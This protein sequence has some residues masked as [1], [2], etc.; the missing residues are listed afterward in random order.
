MAAA[1]FS[2]RW[3]HRNPVLVT[4]LIPSGVEWLGSI[5][6]IVNDGRLLTNP[7]RS[8]EP[9]ELGLENSFDWLDSESESLLMEDF[10]NDILSP[11]AIAEETDLYSSRNGLLTNFALWPGP[12]T[13]ADFRALMF[14]PW[15]SENFGLKSIII[16]PNAQLFVQ[17][18]LHRRHENRSVIRLDYLERLVKAHPEFSP[19]P[20]E[21][22]L[23]LEEHFEQYTAVYAILNHWLAWEAEQNEEFFLFPYQ[24]L[25]ASPFQAIS[26]L[27]EAV[28]SRMKRNVGDGLKA[29]RISYDGSNYQKIP[30]SP[31]DPEG[32]KTSIH[33]EQA[34][35]IDE[36]LA[37]MNCP[38]Q[39]VAQWEATGAEPELSSKPVSSSSRRGS[40]GRSRS[41]SSRSLESSSNHSFGPSV[42]LEEERPSGSRR[43]R[44][45]SSS[46]SGS[47]RSGSGGRSR[48]RR[49]GSDH[50]SRDED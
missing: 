20:F 46:S 3:V 7:L 21:E 23:N 41:S 15:L 35:R 2:V 5:F 33:P 43:S 36:L 37:R 50:D 22:L 32:W 49:S 27:M 29:V 13:V 9:K 40:S 42:V 4:G 47:R 48:S 16:L 38:A 34:S 26:H 18:M 31:K 11:A 44:S 45:G 14:A 24:G 28:G 8:I 39:G 10:W 1:N 25:F 19:V 6:Q 12:L 17:E 30:H